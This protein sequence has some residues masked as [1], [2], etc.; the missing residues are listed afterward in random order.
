MELRPNF[1]VLRHRIDLAAMHPTLPDRPVLAIECDGATYH[2]I[3]T[4]RDRD[5]LRKAYLERLGWRYHRIWATDWFH[6]R[7]LE[8]ARAVEAFNK[9][10]QQIDSMA[11]KKGAEPDQKAAL[12]KREPETKQEQPATKQRGP[13]P[14]AAVRS[15]IIQYSDSELRD[16]LDWV[17]SDGI[18]KPDEQLV[19]ELFSLLPFEKMGPRIRARLTEIVETRQR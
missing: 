18:S 7:E 12:G 17:L 4:V 5:Y 14:E 9:T 2:S 13:K 1:G 11:P 8:I 10:V 3:P 6:N 16:L 15:D 19:E